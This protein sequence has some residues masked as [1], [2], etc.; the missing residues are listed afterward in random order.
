VQPERPTP[1]V[2][3]LTGTCGSGKTTVSTLL[4]ERAGWVRLCEDDVWVER[5]GKGR[6][7]LG[8]DEHRRKRREVHAV[9]LAGVLRALAA[10][11]PVVVDATV[12]EAPPEALHEYG[13]LFEAHG[14]AWSLRVLHP[15]LEVAVARDASRACWT[16]GARGV[17]ELRAKFT[18]AHF[19]PEWFVDTSDETPEQTAHRLIAAT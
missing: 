5:Y 10:R 3:V 1:H 6:G 17:A 12:H 2:L 13:A 15:R 11:R 19:A 8:S 7:A 9:V 16:V 14:V 18:G 4:A